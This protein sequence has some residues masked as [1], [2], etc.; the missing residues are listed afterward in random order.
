MPPTPRPP[1]KNPSIDID[2]TAPRTPS[3][4]IGSSGPRSDVGLR[5][6]ELTEL[7]IKDLD[8]TRALTVSRAVVE[9]KPKFHPAR[10]RFL[11]KDYP[12]DREYRRF[13]LSAPVAE[14]LQEHV[15]LRSLSPDD[16]LFAMRN[17]ERPQIRQRAVPNP[18]S[19]GLTE[20]NEKGRQY[21]HGT[22]SGYTAGR[23]R[24]DYCRV[25][26]ASYRAKRRAQGRDNPHTPRV[27]ET[28]GHIPRDWFRRTIWTP[29]CM[30]AGLAFTPTMRDLRDAH[31]SWLLA[32]GADIQIVKE[33]LGHA[34]IATT[35]RYLH[36]LPDADET[37]LKALDAIRNR[38]L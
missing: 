30:A 26:F 7:R 33:R 18:T 6:G 2:G 25:A 14:K 21:Q 23:C 5:W 38:G 10:G 31:A 11:V 19:L 27:R 17:D 32:G 22:L 29:A 12:R 15:R 35:E 16:L 28:D 8:R 34:I 13:K 37:A 1:R 36:T 20:P 24:C 9:V 3:V 4:R